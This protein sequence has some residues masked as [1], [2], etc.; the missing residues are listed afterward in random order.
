MA[1]KKL[2]QEIKTYTNNILDASI[3]KLNQFMELNKKKNIDFRLLNKI[4]SEL[5]DLKD[6]DW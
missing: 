3:L 4:K 2:E 5:E 6:T 1:T